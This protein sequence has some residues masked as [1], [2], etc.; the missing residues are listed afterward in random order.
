[1]A[2]F[3]G[4][5]QFVNVST[6]TAKPKI[7]SCSCFRSSDGNPEI[8]W[9]VSGQIRKIDHFVVIASKQGMTSIVGRVHVASPNNSFRFVDFV[10]SEFAG[11]TTYSV[12][13]MFCDRTKGDPVSAGTFRKTKSK[14][15]KV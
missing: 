11:D 2:G 4:V 1:M 9:R 14:R 6:K 15:K 12:V 7:V 3:V 8:T 13:P 10:T 5:Q